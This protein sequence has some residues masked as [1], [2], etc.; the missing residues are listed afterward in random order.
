MSASAVDLETRD[1]IAAFVQEGNE[2][3][4]DAE[5]RIEALED[6]PSEEVVN[7][8]FR[9]FHSL[10]GSAGYLNFGTIHAVTHEA[11][12][13]LALF[14]EGSAPMTAAHQELL[15]EVIDFLRQLIG[16][17]D[18]HLTDGSLQEDARPVV[19]RIQDVISRFRNSDVSSGEGE[20]SATPEEPPRT[21]RREDE[22]ADERNE[23]DLQFI[24][25]LRSLFVV[26]SAEILDRSE[27][28]L[29]H[30][31]PG[32]ENSEHLKGLARELHSLKGNAGILD[33]ESIVKGSGELETI[34]RRMIDGTVG[35]TGPTLQ[36][37]QSELDALREDTS[38]APVAWEEQK[39]SIPAVHLPDPPED[40]HHEGPGSPATGPS[41]GPSTGPSAGPTGSASGGATV[42]VPTE[43]LDRLFE[44]V[45]ELITAESMVVNSPDLDNLDLPIFRK[46][47]GNLA[48]LTRELHETALEVRMVPLHGTFQKMKRLARE[49]ARHCRKEVR[50]EVAGG[51][52]EMDKTV[53][54]KIADPLVHIIRNA[55]DHGIETPE[56]REAAGKD[57]A[58]VVHLTAG[59]E[60]KEIVL[61]I[62][63]DGAGLHRDRILARAHAAGLIPDAGESLSDEAVF[64]LIFH[65]GF[66]T[67]DAVS[68]I[69]GRGVGMDVVRTNIQDVRGRI[70]LA[71]KR[72]A[73]TTITMHIP[74]TMAIID[75]VTVRVGSQRY[76]IDLT[77]I[78]EFLQ[79]D[80]VSRERTADQ[81]E[82]LN[83][84]DRSVPLVH[85]HTLLAS[86]HRETEA[87]GTTGVI[88][89]ARPG[90]LCIPVHEILGTHQMVVKALPDYL[91]SVRGLAGMSIMPDGNVT[92]I[93]DVRA[94]G[95]HLF[96]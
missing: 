52:T 76:S 91:G 8:I 4:E 35:V 43:R 56:D 31:A 44:L 80:T 59:Y 72:G 77:D 39:D 6:S 70:A 26:E 38:R 11:E 88:L 14:R 16:A 79:I 73:G 65:P 12:T 81:R 3:I 84:R 75:T 96:A 28:H 36:L 69:S 22:S 61:T 58:G 86:H 93:L 51:D 62:Q 21:P 30:I 78:E 42:R 13:L 85:L 53:I 23:E 89:H 48:K 50:L 54:E 63:D 7:T 17:V 18:T 82:L 87:P 41:A 34:V 71:S 37:V 19:R 32:Q 94:L 20:P 24:H 83:L 2:L 29:E 67:R 33:L 40:Q 15:I 60:G 90:E 25:H 9:L 68:E 64:E 10:K 27:H 66:S 55:I 45:G 47:A 95:Q 74:V 5:S 46:R 92:Y 57:P 49:T 1:L